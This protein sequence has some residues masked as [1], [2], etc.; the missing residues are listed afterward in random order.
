MNMFLSIASLVL[1][2]SLLSD[3]EGSATDSS[4]LEDQSNNYGNGQ[5]LGELEL[6]SILQQ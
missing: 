6:T 5:E 1:L 3:V 4:V 2:A